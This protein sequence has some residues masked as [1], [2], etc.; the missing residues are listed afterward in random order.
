GFLIGTQANADDL[1]A[2][3]VGNLDTS[4]GNGGKVM[5]DLFGSEDDPGAMVLQ[6]DGK[7]IVAG[8]S[9][10]GDIYGVSLVRYNKEGNLG[11][12]FGQGGKVFTQFHGS[13][14][15]KDVALQADGKILIAGSAIPKGS[16]LEDFALVRYNTDGSLDTSF[17]L[18]GKVTTD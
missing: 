14:W 3:A 13:S 6:P 5:T 12:S 18:G 2:Q 1:E 7:I 8:G 16:S 10:N 4:F 9:F 17:G 11:T 15:A